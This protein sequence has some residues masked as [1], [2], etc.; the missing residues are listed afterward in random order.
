MTQIH[1][2][3]LLN[4]D[5]LEQLI[6][7]EGG[8]HVSIY[9]PTHR[10]TLGFKQDRIRF[11]EALNESER[12]LQDRGLGSDAIEDL[13]GPAQAL[14]PDELFWRHQG[15]GL[16]LLLGPGKAYIYRLPLVVP[17]TTVVSESFYVKPLLQLLDRTGS[18]WV[19]A[20][21][22]AGVRLY[23]ATRY[24]MREI[25][26][27][28]IPR[29]LRDALGYDWEQRSLQFHTGAG[30]AGGSARAAVF[31]GHG[32]PG[33]D[34]K[35]EIAKFFGIVDRGLRRLLGN[36]DAPLVVAAVDYQIS[37]FRR[38]SKYPHVL[39]HGVVGSPKEAG[40]AE[41]HASAWLLV[42]PLFL[43]E[44]NVATARY[45]ELA[46]TGKASQRLDELV[47]AA[48]DGRI[49]T[50]FV[51]IDEQCWGTYDAER[52]E[53]D[54]HPEPERGDR[55]LLDLVASQSLVRGANVHA[56]RRD[57]VP[58]GGPAAAVYRY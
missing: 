33:D 36:G 46:G 31:H 57:Q 43:H 48:F 11:E 38:V 58:G 6:A 8:S 18:F 12:R 34:K 35:E 4:R 24:S 15:D 50:L 7:D 41:L 27:L 55:D 53:I 47:P 54:R 32:E 9:L 30:R 45:D 42:E 37:M 10:H 51:A 39:E 56:V 16:A 22:Q 40:V 28:D 49:E 52:R 2:P 44:Q 29:N 13:L 14:L 20:I 25:D 21:G 23:E 5:D 26:L 19:L 1:E 3:T 17:E